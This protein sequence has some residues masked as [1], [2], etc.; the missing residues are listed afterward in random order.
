MRR[1]SFTPQEQARNADAWVTAWRTLQASTERVDRERAERALSALYQERG[2]EAPEFLWV[3]DPTSAILAWHLVS[4][5]REPLRNPFTRGNV[6]NGAE[7]AFHQL[8][9]PFGLDPAWT[10]RA[11]RRIATMAPAGFD[12]DA[13]Y[14][15]DGAAVRWHL[16]RSLQPESPVRKED[17]G[18]SEVMA[19]TA[20]TE[21]LSRIILGRHRQ[22]L[23][24]VLGPAR[25]VD[26]AVRAA[27]RAAEE[28]IDP[29][30]SHRDARQS[31][32]FPA[33]DRTILALAAL[34]EV[35]GR[36]LWRQ[37]DERAERTA[38]VE[39]RLEL[40]RTGVAFAALTGLA[41][42]LDRPTRSRFDERGRLHAEDGAAF[43]Y[44]GGPAIWAVHGVVVP[45]DVITD[46]A[47]IT[48]ERIDEASNAEIRRVLTERF[49]AER[50]IREGGA[51]L[52]DEDDVGR[53]WVRRFPR[54]DWR[55]PEPV[56]MVE[57][58]NST[59]EPD[60]SVR[61]Y[62][63]R[64][65]PSISTARAAVAWTFGLRSSHYEPV[66]ET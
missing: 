11:L 61:T 48:V 24:D 14:A 58:R 3:D 39:R 35:L 10:Y 53:L 16:E 2:L 31:L 18:P 15:A 44:P 36:P 64:V 5:G 41:I 20:R 54:T 37:L 42:M 47:S 57:V 30:F 4:C 27:Q 32:T 38:M 66:V 51:E 62:F 50:L 17:A 40:A 23:L 56:Q 1:K 43:E 33:Y 49:G 60:G 6:G 7:R 45:A 52:V 21:M 34:R 59:P 28:L 19:P 65:P 9:D 8:Q 25:T 13:G 26:V 55:H 12:F 63:L 22:R 29:R 46:P